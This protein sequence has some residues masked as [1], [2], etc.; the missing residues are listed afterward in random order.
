MG[1]ALFYVTPFRVERRSFS[2][3]KMGG[4]SGGRFCR[5]AV[6][7]EGG[8]RKNG[9]WRWCFCGRIVVECVVIVD[10]NRRFDDSEKC[11]TNLEFF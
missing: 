1:M 2:W 8:F 3:K 10:K 9:R 7:F 5:F 6:F 4:G 11:A